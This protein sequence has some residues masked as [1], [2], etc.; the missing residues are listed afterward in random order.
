MKKK[1]ISPIILMAIVCNPS[2]VEGTTPPSD[3]GNK[4]NLDARTGGIP[5]LSFLVCDDSFELP[6]TGIDPVT[7]LPSSN[8]DHLWNNPANV[9]WA[10]CNE[11]LIVT[12]EILGQKPKGSVTKRRLSSCGPE[13][14]IAGEKTITFQDFNADKETLIDYDYWDFII[15]NQKFLKPGYFTCDGRWFQ[16][17]GDWGLELDEVI[18]DTKDGASFYDGTI[19]LSTADLLKPIFAPNALEAIRSFNSQNCYT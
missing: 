18:E 1:S 4:C 2:C 12:G 19:T 6:Y 7:G 3:Y 5:R 15:K 17:A 9:T 8:P 11:K 13:K 14:V 10:I 16:Y